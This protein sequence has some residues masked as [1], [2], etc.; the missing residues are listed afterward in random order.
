MAKALGTPLRLLPVPAAL[1]R[2]AGQLMG[3]GPAISRL[4]GSLKVDSNPLRRDLGWQPP[5]SVDQGLEQ[6]AT[7][8]KSRGEEHTQAKDPDAA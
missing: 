7:W 5:F 1:L 8:Y 2:L 3:R 4:T 6:T